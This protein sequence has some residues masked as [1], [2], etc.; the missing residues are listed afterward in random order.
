MPENQPLQQRV[1][2]NIGTEVLPPFI[3]GGAMPEIPLKYPGTTTIMEGQE[4]VVR[5][6]CVM[7]DG[8]NFGFL[9]N[10]SD[11]D[12]NFF[13]FFVDAEGNEMQIGHSGV[14][15]HES[16]EL[17]LNELYFLI[18]LFLGLC[19]GEKI[20]IRTETYEEPELP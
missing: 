1:G 7:A 6:P 14:G 10:Q 15:D 3:N 19:P 9:F 16:Q 5:T 12:V 2:R 8:A 17:A 18:G 11:D 20:I 13:V 4:G